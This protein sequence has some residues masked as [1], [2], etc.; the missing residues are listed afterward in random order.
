MAH[1][2]A[3]LN[4]DYIDD[5]IYIGN[6]TCCQTHFDERLKEKDITADMSLEEGRVDS[7]LGADYYVWIPVADH[8]APAQ[9]KLAFGVSVLEKWVQMGEKIYVHCRNGHGRAPT[10]VAAYFI[11]T[12]G[13]SPLKAEEF[14]KSKRSAMH[15]E[16]VQRAALEHFLLS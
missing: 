5:G 7:P 14:V 2:L 1:E 12:R 13:W 6:N 16:D 4:F 15:L 11:K 8:T 10:M 9:S 3:E